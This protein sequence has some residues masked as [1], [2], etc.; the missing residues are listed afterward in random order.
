MA[1][2]HAAR[3]SPTRSR[4][5]G[6]PTAPAIDGTPGRMTSIDPATSATVGASAAVVS[7]V[8]DSGTMPAVGDVPYVGRM[9]TMPQSAAGTR[10]DA[11]VS[12]PSDMTLI[13]V[14]TAIADPP[15]DPPGMRVR[16]CGLRA[17]G[18][19]TPSAYS[20]VDVFPTMTAPAARSSATAAAS[21]SGCSS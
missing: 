9:P 14:V 13:P 5:T 2:S 15:D 20:C 8:H 4:S 21:T 7:I 17:C 3:G 18:L 6:A 16:S 19:V 1:S 11:R 10:I 12:V